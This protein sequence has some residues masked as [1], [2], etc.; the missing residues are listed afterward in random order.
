MLD[1]ERLLDL[2]SEWHDAHSEGQLVAP[3]DVC[4]AYPDYAPE[5]ERI[6]R[7]TA[8]IEELLPSSDATPPR[9]Q[10]CELP[11]PSRLGSY[12]V[13]RLLGRGSFGL[14]YLGRHEKLGHAAA[15][16]VPLERTEREVKRFLAEAKAARD[17]RHEGIVG[18]YD[19]D[20]TAD[21]GCYIAMQYVEGPTL[22]QFLASRGHLSPPEAAALVASVAEALHSAH[23]SKCVHRDL[24]PENILLAA[25]GTH[26]RISDFGLA[27][28]EERRVD[29][30]RQGGTI[31]YMAPEQLKGDYYPSAQS[32]VWAIGVM[33]Y[34]L[35]VGERPFV[36]THAAS[37][38]DQILHRQPPTLL[39]LFPELTELDRI[40]TKCLAQPFEK[41]YRTADQV[42]NDLRSWLAPTKA[43]H[44]RRG[45]RLVFGLLAVVVTGLS[46][47]WHP[48]I[49]RSRDISPVPSS[50]T[51]PVRANTVVTIS[52][53]QE[54]ENVAPVIATTQPTF[55]W[56][57]V[58]G[59]TGYGF[60]LFDATSGQKC[61]EREGSDQ[62]HGTSFTIPPGLLEFGRT[63]RW[64]MRYFYGD[65]GESKFCRAKLFRVE[66]IVPPIL[67]HP[68][69]VGSAGSRIPTLTPTFEWDTAGEATG[70]GLFI[71]DVQSDS[72]VYDTEKL[73]VMLRGT[74][75]A[76]PAGILQPGR[77]Y[78]W[79]MAAFLGDKRPVYTRPGLYFETP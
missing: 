1:R 67:R 39:R 32:D 30:D 43:P 40:Y 12:R 74:S 5:L 45:A 71:K 62:L 60:Y 68:G 35:L 13:E 6:I 41:R 17:L 58:A 21:G 11:L 36:G 44:R 48:L 61:C 8:L 15:I 16:K 3:A 4:A 49:G 70:Y 51:A 9:T 57:P 34:E 27:G 37:L 28:D 26:P 31:A 7:K 47:Y 25:D 69:S 14:V 56:A 76:L 38:K 79:N 53:G 29:E 24:K 10:S 59:A 20:R 18:I 63:Y 52:P 73:G 55:T 75:F 72:V 65:G 54:G 50:T 19:F 22:R 42:A 33:L 2:Y 66:E 77:Q 46:L 23:K 64:N 78:R